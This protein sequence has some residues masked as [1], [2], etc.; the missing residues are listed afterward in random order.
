ME[1]TELTQKKCVPCRGGI[2]PMEPD[3]AR[4][5]LPAAEGW[6]LSEN[7]RRISKRF[8]FPTFPDAI[9]FV[10]RLAELAENEGHHPDLEI[11]YNKVD[12]VF[13]THKI[14]GLHE[15]DFIMA[16]KTNELASG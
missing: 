8:S 13:W 16:A 2:P 14:D 5:Y 10:N 1:V 12:V 11:H 3:R 15:N 4:E 7:V 6:S 9:A